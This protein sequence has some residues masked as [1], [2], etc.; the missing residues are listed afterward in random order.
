MKQQILNKILT[1]K[2]NE[3]TT[4]GEYCYYD[5]TC[6]KIYPEEDTYKLYKE[7]SFKTILDTLGITLED[8][9]LKTYIGAENLVA[10]KEGS[11]T[12]Y[13][14]GVRYFVYYEYNLD[15]MI[16]LLKI[17]KNCKTKKDKK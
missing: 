8:I 12:D 10:K 1:T 13:Y 14:G 9:S 2:S 16:D 5:G 7:S 15:K 6:D 17:V 4:G 3:Y 11:E